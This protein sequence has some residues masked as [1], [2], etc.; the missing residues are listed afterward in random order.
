MGHWHCWLRQSPS[1][2]THPERRLSKKK[3]QFLPPIALSNPPSFFLPCSS[4]RK[5][6]PDQQK[7]ISEPFPICRNPSFQVERPF[8][9]RYLIIL[10]GVG[11]GFFPP[12]QVTQAAL[13]KC[14]CE[15]AGRSS[16]TVGAGEKKS[17]RKK[18]RER[19]RRWKS[20]IATSQFKV[21]V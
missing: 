17:P 13:G 15:E 18:K 5:S 6:C 11:G 10:G 7:K 21:T 19:K 9:R 3:S 2:T 16:L 1:C 12:P 4:P 14:W 8:R 20:K